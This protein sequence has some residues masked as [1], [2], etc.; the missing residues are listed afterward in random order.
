[1]LLEKCL[2]EN[3]AEVHTGFRGR[4]KYFRLWSASGLPGYTQP[5]KGGAFSR[6]AARGQMIF[7][8]STQELL[9]Y[10]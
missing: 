8:Q 10:G 2:V 1:M 3:L 6:N 4:R 9:L 5:F 7:P